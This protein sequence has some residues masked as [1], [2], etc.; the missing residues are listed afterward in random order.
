MRAALKAGDAESVR[1]L[2]ESLPF[3][4][5]EFLGLNSKIFLK[6]KIKDIDLA[7]YEVDQLGRVK[8]KS[9]SVEKK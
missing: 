2:V 8:A 5:F 4:V 3:S 9:L 1:T 7:A 6:G